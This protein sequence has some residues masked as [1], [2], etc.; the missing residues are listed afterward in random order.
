MSTTS[1]AAGGRGWGGQNKISNLSKL[2]EV[3]FVQIPAVHLSTLGSTPLTGNPTKSIRM[4][5]GEC[6]GWPKEVGE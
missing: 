1:L 5:S 3:A 4:G 2:T 6:R